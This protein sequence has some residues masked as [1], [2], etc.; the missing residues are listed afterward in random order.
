MWFPRDRISIK[1]KNDRIICFDRKTNYSVF[2]RS[3]RLI[4]KV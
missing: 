3:L 2:F 1:A 4:W